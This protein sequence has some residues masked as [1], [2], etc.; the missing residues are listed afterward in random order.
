MRRVH[1]SIKV[2]RRGEK[3]N[4]E[5]ASKGR[6]AV[7]SQAKAGASAPRTGKHHPGETG[8]SPIFPDRKG[9]AGS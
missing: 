4:K 6:G 5:K 2:G 9:L 3:R 7:R 8:P 1:T